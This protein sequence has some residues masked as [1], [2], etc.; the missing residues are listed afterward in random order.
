M[1]QDRG[2]RDGRPVATLAVK[3]RYYQR[4]VEFFRILK[5]I[6]MWPSRRGILH[7][8]YTFN[9]LGHYAEIITHCGKR[10]TV[11]NSKNSRAARWLRNKWFR[12]PCPACAIPE[13]KMEKYASTFFSRHYGS[14]LSDA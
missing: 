10:F 8:I 1:S 11:R 4:R 6:K 13:W 7:S 9:E 5:K 14:T 3:K 12:K 2:V